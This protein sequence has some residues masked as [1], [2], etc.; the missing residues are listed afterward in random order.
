MVISI[1][2]VIVAV[3]FIIFISSQAIDLFSCYCN[4]LYSLQGLL[5]SFFGTIAFI[6]VVPKGYPLSS[7]LSHPHPQR[8]RT[9]KGD[10][11][12]GG[13]LVI[14]LLCLAITVFHGGN[15]K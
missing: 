10:L 5:Y 2:V 15:S 7:L 9:I 1:F 8:T 6:Q 14:A 3:C 4:W 13:A 12:E 11:L